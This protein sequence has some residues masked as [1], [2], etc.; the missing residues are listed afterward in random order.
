MFKFIFTI[1]LGLSLFAMVN[2]A[3][4]KQYASPLSGLHAES[5]KLLG[6]GIKVVKTMFL[7][8]VDKVAAEKDKQSSTEK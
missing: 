4:I 1:I 5:L 7:T 3:L 2:P 8:A 6:P